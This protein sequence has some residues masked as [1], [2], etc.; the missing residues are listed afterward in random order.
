MRGK[1]KIQRNEADNVIVT[2][3]CRPCQEQYCV[4]IKRALEPETPKCDK[5]GEDYPIFLFLEVYFRLDKMS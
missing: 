1:L 4:D 5:C 3:R 2:F